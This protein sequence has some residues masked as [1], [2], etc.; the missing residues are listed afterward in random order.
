MGDWPE[1]PL[2]EIVEVAVGGL[3]GSETPTLKEDTPV[4]VIRGIDAHKMSQREA[5]D[6]PIRWVSAKQLA[7]RILHVG[8][9]VLEASGACGRSYVMRD[10]D[11]EGQPI[12]VS[13]S[14]FSRRLIPNA[15]VEPAYLGYRLRQAY[16]SGEISSY[17]TGTAMPNL[18]VHSALAG[19]T[20]HLPPIQKQREVAEILGALDDKIELNRRMNTTLE[21]IARALFQSWFIDF[22]P[23]RAKAEGRQP[24]CMDAETAALFPDSLEESVIGPIPKGWAC[25]NMAS[26]IESTIN[27]D[28]GS[29]E[30][31]TDDEIA[32]YC[33]RGADIPALRRGDSETLPTRY[34]AGKSLMKRKLQDGDL[35]L[36]ISGGSPT[37]STGRTVYISGALIAGL[38]Q[39]LVCSNFCRVVRPLDNK[40]G[41]VLYAW[42][43]HRYL[44]GALFQYETGTTGIKNLSYTILFEDSTL[45]FPG[46]SLLQEFSR[47]V[48]HLHGMMVHNA[49][50]I[51]K[52]RK[53]R[54]SLLPKLFSG[55]LRVG[56]V[57]A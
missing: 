31:K 23:V 2:G 8:D 28:W 46:G 56:D 13:F 55:E 24:V 52:L 5:V 47:S 39:P 1:V 17:V 51:Q 32:T 41:L 42:L 36:E 54:D 18:D 45:A 15:R 27:G 26:F 4:R 34:I 22:D 9:V 30:A 19:I 21:S 44:N 48:S 14:N 40:L 10:S 57:A 37:Q 49:G 12:P 33:A 53:L 29:D 7:S 16:E 3:W 25:R 50:E 38:S 43:N 11:V 20:I 35:V 6:L